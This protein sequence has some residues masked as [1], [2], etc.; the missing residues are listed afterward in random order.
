MN[1]RAVL[2]MLGA[3]AC[4]GI[5][6]VVSKQA[7]VEVPPLTLLAAQL[8]VS[9]VFLAVLGRVRGQR[10][11]P[12]R[13]AAPLV[14]LGILN[15]GLAYALG[16]IGLSQ[17]SASLA[18]LLWA[19]EPILILG[20]A[21]ILLGERLETRV[22]ALSTIAVTGLVVVIYDPAATGSLPGVA[23]SIAGIGC[24]A[25]YAIATRRWLS[26]AGETLG[27]VLGQQAAALAFA[28]A[29]VAASAW[30]GQPPIAAAISPVGLASVAISGLLYYAFAYLLYLSAL[31]TLPASAAAVAFYLIPLFGVGAATVAGERLGPTQELGALVVIVAVAAVGLRIAGLRMTLARVSRVPPS[32]AVD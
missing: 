19:G 11:L 7:V 20:L 18:V 22:I 28:I 6:T 9:V 23:V 27:V 5:G 13:R 21:A 12:V 32:R 3:A 8:A 17:I 2:A 4:W 29:L 31:R 15:P 30:A 25:V 26:D 16:L 1:R 14:A 10:L 24:C